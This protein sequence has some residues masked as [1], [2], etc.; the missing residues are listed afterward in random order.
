MSGRTLYP[1]IIVLILFLG[2]TRT[3]IAAEPTAIDDAT[4]SRCLTVLREGL[5][6]EA[7]WPS[8][9]AAE[10]LTLA[11]QHS[12]VISA[13]LPRLREEEDSQRRCGLA[14]ELVRAGHEPALAVLFEILASDDPHGHGH[15]CE[16]LLK[17]DRRGD[18]KLLRHQW[19]NGDGLILQLLAAAA[20]A[21][22]GDEAAVGSIRQQ[23]ANQD[24]NVARIAAWL[25]SFVGDA[26]DLPRLQSRLESVE[27]E[28]HQIFFLAALAT[29]GD[30][31]A[32]EKLQQELA[33]ADPQVRVYAA[34]FCGTA[35][36]KSALP[37]LIERLNDDDLDVRIRAAQAILRLAPP[38]K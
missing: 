15:A 2:G 10:A 19:K 34:E 23:L 30:E 29:L 36:I 8:M 13:L 32:R 1:L 24:D 16:S 37:R 6:A 26:S 5:Q 18:G 14:R 11:G 4:R 9:H 21:R 27:A 31:Q 3:G 22:G 33:N 20:L 38:H 25:L 35:R 17:I 12:E 28:N 7:F